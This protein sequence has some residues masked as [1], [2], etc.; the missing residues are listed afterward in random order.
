MFNIYVS[1]S[2]PAKSYH[3]IYLKMPET[4][5]HH[6]TAEMDALCSGAFPRMCTAAAYGHKRMTSIIQ[7]Q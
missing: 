3:A 7:K 6:G 1:F 4:Q 2:H 5:K